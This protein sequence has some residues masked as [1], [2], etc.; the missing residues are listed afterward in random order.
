[1][2]EHKLIKW[3]VNS[4]ISPLRVQ[5]RKACHFVHTYN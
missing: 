4:V 2:V 5:E 3:N 1:M